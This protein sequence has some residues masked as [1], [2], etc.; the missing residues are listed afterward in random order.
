MFKV[1]IKTSP[2][3]TNPKSTGQQED[4]GLVRNLRGMQNSP[5]QYAVNDTM[6]AIPRDQANIEVEGG[7]SVLGDINKDGIMELMHFNGKRHTEGG[8]PVNIPEGSFI[9]S[10]TKNLTIKDPEVLEKIFN[11]PFRKQGYTPGEISKKYDIN[12]YVQILK[13]DTSDPLAKRS[14]A[15]MLKKNKQKLGLLAFIQESMKGFPDG[16]PAIAEEVLSSMGIDP[17][18]MAQQFAPQQQQGQMPQG[19]M[20]PPPQEGQGI[21]MSEDESAMQGM[22]PEGPAVAPE[23]LANQFSGKFGGVMPRYEYEDAGTVDSGC[24]PMYTWNSYVK[25]CVL[26]M[27]SRLQTVP[28]FAIAGYNFDKGIP[29]L[30]DLYSKAQKQKQQK[31]K[32]EV[33][34]PRALLTNA[35]TQRVRIKE[36]PLSEEEKAYEYFLGKPAPAKVEPIPGSMQLQGNPYAK[37]YDKE[38]GEE[39]KNIIYDKAAEERK[40]AERLAKEELRLAKEKRDN[41]YKDNI[42]GFGSASNL[43][44]YMSE[45]YQ[46]QVAGDTFYKAL[47]SNDPGLMMQAADDIKNIDIPWNVGWLPWTDQDKIDDMYTILHEEALKKLNEKQKDII[48][49]DYSVNT[50]KTK[51]NDIITKYQKLRDDATDV[52][53]KLKY[54]EILDKYSKYKKQLIDNGT[55]NNYIGGVKRSDVK[56]NTSWFAHDVPFF[57]SDLGDPIQD[58][59]INYY[60]RE[61]IPGPDDEI[62]MMSIIEDITKAHDV[63]KKTNVAS[64]SPLAFKGQISAG[65]TG[66]GD[67]MSFG[68]PSQ[69]FEISSTEGRV[70]SVYDKLYGKKN[71]PKDAKGYM[72]EY[73]LNA[74][75]GSTFVM[76]KNLD[77]QM[78]WFE[79]TEDGAELEVTNPEW[80]TTLNAAATNKERRKVFLRPAKAPVD[81]IEMLEE[82]KRLN[83]PLDPTNTKPKTDVIAPVGKKPINSEKPKQKYET[84]GVDDALFDELFGKGSM[85]FGGTMK[86]IGSDVTIGDKVFRYEGLINE[87]GKLRYDRGGSVLPKYGLA[88]TVTDPTVPVK[89]PETT[90]T[91]HGFYDN[92]P[93]I[94]YTET[95]ASKDPKKGPTVIA[96]IL[97]AATR[98]ILD[99]QNR[100]TGEA[101]PKDAQVTRSSY[102]YVTS[103]DDLN[104]YEKKVLANNWNG[105]E[106]EYITFLNSSNQMRTNPDFKKD[107]YAQYEKDIELDNSYTHRASGKTKFRPT[108]AADADEMMNS[109]LAFE[110]KNARLQ[111]YGNKSA[112]TEN[113]VAGGTGQ[114]RFINK[115][116]ND[117]INANPTALGD[118]DFSKGYQGQAA[119]IAYNNLLTKDPKYTA[120]KFASPQ[121]GIADENIGYGEGTVSGID[122]ILVNTTLFQRLGWNA[123]APPPED[124]PGEKN[125]YYCVDYTDG[126][127]DVHTVPYKEPALP[128]PPVVGETLNGKVIK[129]LVTFSDLATAQ[130]TCKTTTTTKIPPG[131]TPP[132]QPQGW[133]APDIV[134]YAAASRQI[135]PNTPPT[136]QQISQPISGYDTI[137]PITKIA[138]TTGLMRQQGDLA[139]NTMDATTG[140]AAMAGQGYDKLAEQIGGVEEYN[141]T[142]IVNPYLTRVGNLAVDVDYKNSIF[143]Q[144]FNQEGAIYQEE[145]AAQRNKKDAQEAMLYG[146]GWGNVQK[147]N[148]L[149]VANPNAWHANRLSPTF[150]WSGIGKDPLSG[151]IITGVTTEDCSAVYTQAFDVA[152]ANPNM[153]DAARKTYADTA[154]KNC[155]ARNNTQTNKSQQQQ[156]NAGLPTFSVRYGGTIYTAPGAMEYGGM[157]YDD[158]NN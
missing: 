93:I 57:S 153:D 137:N 46:Q 115:S 6:G 45:N 16:I 84:E 154:M 62:T 81:I 70:K 102:D 103:K 113:S 10:D 140:F 25:K 157:F 118:L 13:D 17:N 80:V 145:L 53:G 110:E 23:D 104:D 123:T 96:Y 47:L 69:S 49:K 36:A 151:N 55:Y 65:G 101:V 79:V 67:T 59:Y 14:A 88:G 76:D 37:K 99:R 12:M 116:A 27:Y 38:T 41:P 64:T 71:T 125:A 155:M 132:G 7:E 66:R 4:Y 142:N 149:R 121:F 60:G 144:A 129:G 106:K 130:T 98:D 33:F 89:S 61:F 15:E 35:Q 1:R 21:P 85:K 43:K 34:D 124:K 143:N 117:I 75:P 139:M 8:I 95:Y 141:A 127:K 126:T 50:I 92:K 20:M 22:I 128:I 9:F 156:Y 3:E 148:S 133:F 30:P 56:S 108:L 19:Q 135:I 24:P 26:A 111:A 44:S 105:N 48:L 134:N 2:G 112:G 90:T 146:Q 39:L 54:A 119:Y 63:I 100:T 150:Q 114:G 86:S 147:D 68:D 91:K 82:E 77:G 158:D 83:P 138:G 122:N 73:K 18:Q 78:I 52:K 94:I 11:L 58:Q 5:E 32:E 107:L 97:D 74:A 136:L 31:E 28:D 51:L 87:N 29:D 109:L 120:Q 42:P 131:K 40:A 152:K 72:Q